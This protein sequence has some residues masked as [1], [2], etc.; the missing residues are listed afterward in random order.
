MWIVKQWWLW[1]PSTLTMAP[2]APWK[3]TVEI[4]ILTPI[5]RYMLELFVESG[6]PIDYTRST[7][8]VEVGE[9]DNFLWAVF[10]SSI[11][12]RFRLRR[13][14]STAPRKFQFWDL[15]CLILLSLTYNYIAGREWVKYICN[16]YGQV[17][18]D[19]E[20]RKI[21][22]QSS[23]AGDKAF[24]QIQVTPGWVPMNGALYFIWFIFNLYIVPM[25][26]TL[27]LFLFIF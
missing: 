5:Y 7:P 19:F 1:M 17:G 18:W 8:E 9:S 4:S 27:Y 13:R 11:W 25:N 24:V 2:L 12:C 15:C 23:R 16:K 14:S 3:A 20:L 21:K 26:G 22:L 10:F 6:S